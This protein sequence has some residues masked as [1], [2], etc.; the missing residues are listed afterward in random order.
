MGQQV[1][2]I[3]FPFSSPLVLSSVFFGGLASSARKIANAT[4]KPAQ[5][6]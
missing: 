2:L 5:R 3:L 1:H 4:E 6:K